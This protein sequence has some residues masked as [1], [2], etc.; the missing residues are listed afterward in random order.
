LQKFATKEK[1]ESSVWGGGRGGGI[2]FQLHNIFI[3]NV[4]KFFYG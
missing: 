2:S 1:T 4:A 3:V